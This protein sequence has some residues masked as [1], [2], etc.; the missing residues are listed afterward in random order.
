MGKKRSL[1]YLEDGYVAIGY[2]HGKARGNLAAWLNGLH[3]PNMAEGQI[4]KVR[5]KLEIARSFR[6]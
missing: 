4:G 2:W 3:S 6:R 1:K 5:E